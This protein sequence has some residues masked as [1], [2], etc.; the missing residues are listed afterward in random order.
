MSAWDEVTPDQLRATVRVVLRDVLPD[1]LSVVRAERTDSGAQAPRPRTR[2]VVADDADLDRLVREVADRAADP[3]VRAAM[4]AGRHGFRL[5][6]PPP[7][8]G[9]SASAG[10]PATDA[11]SLQADAVVRVDRGA[12]T[13]RHV[14]R[15]AVEGARLVIGPRAVVTPLARDRARALGIVFDAATD[16]DPT[17]RPNPERSH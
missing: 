3:E 4:A 9:R 2:V 15:A 1:L 11:A 12:V 10:S 5:D 8:S 17:I 7:A 16:I 13:E 6:R 14:R